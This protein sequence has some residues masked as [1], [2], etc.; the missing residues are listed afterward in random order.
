MSV[1]RLA[2]E[3]S[4]YLR[5]HA[6][7]PVE[8]YPWG[9]EALR[10]AREQDRP[11]FVSIG[12]ASCHWC[13]VMA[14]ES[15][16][17]PATAAELSNW[18]VSVKVDRE[19]RP[20]L[21][22]VYM[23]AT[24]ALTGSGGWPM[25]VFCTP[26]GLPFYAGTY[27]PPG[28]ASRD[29]LLPAC[30][31]SARGGVA[32]TAG[33]GPGP[34]RGTRTGG[35]QGDGSR[36]VDARG[37][38]PSARHPGR[39]TGA[40]GAV[41]LGAQ[42]LDTDSL[43]EQVV[44]GLAAGYDPEWGGFGP[45]PKFPRPSL[46]ELCL[47]RSRRGGGDA[48]QARSMALRTLDAMAAGGIYDHLV[49]GFCR[50][51][52]DARWL[53]PHFEKMLTDQALLSRAYL[54]AW[55]ETGHAD[56][57]GVVTETLDFV[58]RDLSTPD[59]A[60][61]SSFDADAG[62]V[63]GAHATFTMGDLEAGLPP[64]LRQA[65]AEWYGISERGNW[66]GRSIPVRPVGAPL[67]R[68][69]DIEEARSLLAAIRAG[70]VQPARDEKVLTEWNAMAVATLAE[71][72]SATGLAE[73]GRRAE[74]IGEFL[75]ASM[76][77]DGRLMRSWQ[78]G[79]ARHLGV[80]ADHA[81]M[82]EAFV[83]LSEWSGHARWRE[84]ALTVSGQLLDL[85]RDEER[86]GFFTTGKD[87]EALVVRP[88]EFVD[89]AVPATQFHRGGVTAAGRRTDRRHET[90]GSRVGDGRAR[91]AT[92]RAAP[93]GPGRPRGR[94][95]HVGGATGDRR[96]RP[97]TRSGGRDTP[98]VAA[99]CRPGVGG[100]GRRAALRRTSPRAWRRVR[101]PP[102]DVSP[103]GARRGAA[104]RAARRGG[105]GPMTNGDRTG[106][107]IDQKDVSDED[108]EAEQKTSTGQN[109]ARLLRRSARRKEK[110][111]TAGGSTLHLLVLASTV[112]DTTV[113]D[114]AT[115]TV[116][117]IR[118]P[119]PEGHDPD[120]N[121]FDVVEVMLADDPERDDLAQPEATTVDDLPRHIGT[122]RGRRLRK[123]LQR[124]VAAPDGPL[125]GFPG[126][127]A[128]YWEFRGFRPSVALDRA[129]SE[130]A[131]DQATDG[132]LDLGPVRLGP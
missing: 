31:P 19:E 58:L 11:L 16:E 36:R 102:K 50:Y 97:T 127:S 46:V 59:G 10:L 120:I 124:L 90:R 37:P 132:R 32:A 74:E 1:N 76:Y 34:G 57:L 9:D 14:H 119:W 129:H 109:P 8:W 54:H 114:L 83:R 73:Y 71:A 112:E 91:R 121:P 122:L 29:A 68:P 104:V 81:W 130:S 100:T 17:D 111:P 26:D 44:V 82:V 65:A 23:A 101:V 108:P 67:A 87:A 99:C 64:R 30:R 52:T 126:A 12:Y 21:D 63:E 118:V 89:G 55:Q 128:P 35:P 38:W 110:V 103:P 61:Y 94:A 27:F 41:A 18:F 96:D 98:T 72:A 43:Q 42:A 66:E 62:G 47:R 86:G 69:D 116:M 75:W 40:L 107:A 25:S 70:R 88:K 3:T 125:L 113:V 93:R 92:A 45:A 85:F 5:Q 2:D 39:D 80:A 56:Y 28:G 22:T 15:F 60:L 33:S 106:D 13:H 105:A 95:A 53:V 51:S 24:Q 49:G 79:R 84:R 7:N 77:V 115:R 20:D 78:G 131:A 6:G 4:P 117:R 48:E 123:L